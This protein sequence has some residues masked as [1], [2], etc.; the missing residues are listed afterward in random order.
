MHAVGRQHFQRAGA[1]RR[2][3]RMG[4]EADEQRA[5]D[6]LGFAVQA[7]GLADGEHVPFVE[8]QF[9]R[10]APVPGGTEGD[11]LGGDRCIGL[12]GVIGRNQSRDIYQQLGWRRFARKRTDCHA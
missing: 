9:E 4:V 10:A 8:A 2:R 1:G 6:A 5:V 12:A 7:D 3:Q 11:A